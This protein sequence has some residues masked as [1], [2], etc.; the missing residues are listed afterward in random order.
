MTNGSTYTD[1]LALTGSNAVPGFW[2]IKACKN[3]GCSGGN[4]VSFRSFTVTGPTTLNV[5]AASGTYG[6]STGAITATL[7]RNSDNSPVQFTTITFTLNGNTVGT[8]NTNAS[9]VATL[10]SASLLSPAK[11]NAGTYP[12]GVGA[13][14]A[15]GGIDQPSTG[16]NTLTITQ[17]AITVTAINNS[18]IYDGTTSALAVPSITTGGPLIAG[19]VA[20]FTE[21]YSTEHVGSGNKTLIPSGTVIDGNSGNN[22]SYTFVNVTSRN[23]FT[24]GTHCYRGHEHQG[25]RRHN[26]SNGHA[27]D[28]GW[29][30]SDWRY[31][32]LH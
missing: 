26:C 16:A 24:Q 15:G 28:H 19:D 12:T 11:I 13:S 4:E 17:K 22:Y 5:T 25:V 21:A 29:C 8:A 7:K 20:N 3:A 30:C 9:G 18:K 1:T 10:L 2:A 32:E 23:S 27:C 31:R 14:F 6:G